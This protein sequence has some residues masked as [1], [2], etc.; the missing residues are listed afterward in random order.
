MYNTE[1]ACL[2]GRHNDYLC[3]LRM[4]LSITWIL[5]LSCGSSSLTIHQL[6]HSNII[7]NNSNILLI[8]I[9]AK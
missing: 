9:S 4:L 6:R 3:I 7:D 1:C 2:S 8:A 5:S